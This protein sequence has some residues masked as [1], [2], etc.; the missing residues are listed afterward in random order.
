MRLKKGFTLAEILIVLMVIGVIATMTVPS[1]MKGVQEAQYKTA[2][3]KA[4]NTIANL[5]A[6][7]GVEGKMP[8]SNTDIETSRFFVAMLEN[9]SVRE[10]S[11]IPLSSR[12]V[13]TRDSEVKLTY[14]ID[15]ND[16]TIGDSQTSVTLNDQYKWATD[17]KE[18][19]ASGDAASGG[20]I[21]ATL[22]DGMAYTLVRGGS[23]QAK[24]LLSQHSDSLLAN[25]C[26]A[27]VVDVNGLNKTPN[28]FEPQA[29]NLGDADMQPLTGDQYRF[30]VATDGI[31]AGSK[32]KQAAA[33][34]I[35]DMK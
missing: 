13:A 4:Y 17:F 7:L 33:R 30:Y 34:I 28:T 20:Q 10:V 12:A 31:T 15:N 14:S 6:K 29:D 23:C 8:I 25:S 27:V 11:Q 32:L 19:E 18:S 26:L 16:K 22:D 35:A 5:T 3:K 21:W 9:T 2:V 1:M 24:N